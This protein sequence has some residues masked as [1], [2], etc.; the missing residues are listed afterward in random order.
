MYFFR[1]EASFS[2]LLPLVSR[3]R[4]KALMDFF[5]FLTSGSFF[6]VAEFGLRESG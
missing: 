6:Y 3:R 1:P 2:M 5:P 4:V